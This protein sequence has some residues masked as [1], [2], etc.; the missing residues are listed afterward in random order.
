MGKP[1]AVKTA[2]HAVKRR[3]GTRGKKTFKYPKE[4]KTKVIP[5]VA[6]SENGKA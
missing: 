1:S 2:L 3:G 5:Q 4:K 6:A